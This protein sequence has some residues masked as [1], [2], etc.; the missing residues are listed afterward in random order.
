MGFMGMSEAYSESMQREIAELKMTLNVN[1]IFG[2]T[3]Q[4]EGPS[5]GKR[6]AFLRVSGCNLTCSWCDTP[7]TWDWKGVNGQVWDKDSETHSMTVYN[8]LYRLTGLGVGLVVIS[9]GEPMMQQEALRPVV[10]RLRAS[11]IDVE[12]ETNGTIKPTIQPTRFNVSPKLVHSG[13]RDKIRFKPDALREY[14][15]KSNFKFVCQTLTDLDEVAAIAKEVGIPNSDIWIMPEG[16][17]PETLMSHA[18][19]ITDQ[20]IARGWN[21]T[22]RLHVMTWGSRRAV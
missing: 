21:I 22:G 20:A 3:I 8:I 10:E 19:I 2:P 18:E 15:G 1:E 7:Y 9:G 17:D 4:G 13:V 5:T 6:C 12:I 16:R 11:G 14:L